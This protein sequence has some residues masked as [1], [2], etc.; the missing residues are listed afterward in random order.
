MLCVRAI[1]RSNWI[2]DIKNAHTP[3]LLRAAL[4]SICGGKNIYNWAHVYESHEHKFHCAESGE[5]CHRAHSLLFWQVKTAWSRGFMC[6]SNSLFPLSLQI[7][8]TTCDQGVFFSRNFRYSDFGRGWPGYN[9]NNSVYSNL[10]WS[11]G[12]TLIG[13]LFTSICRFNTARTAAAILRFWG[14]LSA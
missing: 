9:T 7:H 14:F 1:S 4:P 5:A 12:S 10:G 6:R 3:T 13:E 8:P 11:A 2:S